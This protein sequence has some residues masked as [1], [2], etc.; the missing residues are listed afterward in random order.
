MA[1]ELERVVVAL[2]C[3]IL[4]AELIEMPSWLVRPGK[5]ECGERWPLVRGAL[6]LFNPSDY[7]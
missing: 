1:C 4:G 3:E 2:V 7:D 5:V 6:S